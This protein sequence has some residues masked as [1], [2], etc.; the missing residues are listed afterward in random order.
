MHTKGLN[1]DWTPAGLLAV[2]LFDHRNDQDVV[3]AAYFDHASDYMNV[4]HSPENADV[5]TKLHGIMVKAFEATGS[6]ECL[7]APPV[8]INHHLPG[9]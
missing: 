2:E 4:A 7:R 5:V 3:G 9:I 6:M 8:R 1:A